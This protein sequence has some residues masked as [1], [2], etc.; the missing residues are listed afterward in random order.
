[1]HEQELKKKILTVDDT[2]EN[3]DIIKSILVPFYDVKVAKT[4]A[5]AVQI[6][7][8]QQP[9]LILLDIMMPD[10]DGYEVCRRL[11]NNVVTQNI[12]II[13]LTAMHSEQD[14]LYGF[15]LGVVDYIAKP[16]T[17]AIILARVRTQILLKSKMDLL[18][19]LVSLD[20]LAEILNRRAFDNSLD[21]CWQQALQSRTPLSLIM[22]DIDFFKQYNDHYGHAMGDDCLKRVAK[23]LAQVAKRSADMV[24]RYGGE[25]FASILPNTDERG[26]SKIGEIFLQAVRDLKISHKQS[27]VDP[28]LSV[29]VGVATAHPEPT[30]DM[31]AFLEKTDKMLYQA[32]HNGRNQVFVADS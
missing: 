16:F 6:A 24:A 26:A 13:F 28:F 20:G 25:E 22:I 18:E 23:S 5:L 29:S 17:P 32:K 4:G 30:D 21:E 19:K 1:M 3:L 12:P 2:P 9:D 8:A 10:M 27:K 11:K 7:E 14:E 15:K 31:L